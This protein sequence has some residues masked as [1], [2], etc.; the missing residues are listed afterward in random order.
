[1]TLTSIPLGR[2][3][4]GLVRFYIARS[5]YLNPVLLTSPG[6]MHLRREKWLCKAASEDLICVLPTSFI[7]D[8]PG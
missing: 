5:F 2:G 3:Y 6:Y 4:L 8:W 1:M 7:F